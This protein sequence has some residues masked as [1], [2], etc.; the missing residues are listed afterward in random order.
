[1]AEPISPETQSEFEKMSNWDRI[2]WRLAHPWYSANPFVGIPSFVMGSSNPKSPINV[3]QQQDMERKRAQEAQ[4]Q[5]N[6]TEILNRVRE[7][8]KAANQPAYSQAE[9][10]KNLFAGMA[11]R[12]PSAP[13]YASLAAKASAAETAALNKWLGGV[14]TAGETQA[15]AIEAAYNEAAARSN[16]ASQAEGA[17][18]AEAAGGLEN[19][20]RNMISNQAADAAA[21]RGAG[22]LAGLTGS[23]G[24]QATAQ[25]V[26]GTRLRTMLDFM[27]RETGARRTDIEEIG[28]QQALMGKAGKNEL[29]NMI[30]AA[31]GA[32][33]YA[34]A[35]KNADRSYQAQVAAAQARSA[36]EADRLA[37]ERGQQ[38]QVTQATL[39]DLVGQAAKAAEG[40]QARAKAY[41]TWDQMDESKRA[42]LEYALGTDAKNVFADWVEADP[43][44]LYEYLPSG[45]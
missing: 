37:W 13:D 22:S 41:A 35:Q 2:K 11:Y 23:S 29:L 38:E 43:T 33:Q 36:A 4:K 28:R 31:E 14:R 34:Q 17:S 19:L 18:G 8:R 15:N 1:M 30:N 6:Y 10:L 3:A 32:R 5:A 24:D 45:K 7:A 40:R 26:A 12:A 16:L 44:I 27:G 39:Q 21:A 42:E 9:A 25:D 20:Y